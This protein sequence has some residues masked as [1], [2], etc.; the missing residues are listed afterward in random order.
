MAGAKPHWWRGTLVDPGLGDW[1]S[2]DVVQA[3]T[4][5]EDVRVDLNVIAKVVA[6]LNVVVVT[7]VAVMPF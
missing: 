2:K 7:V 1:V 4:G 5:R 6:R 3:E